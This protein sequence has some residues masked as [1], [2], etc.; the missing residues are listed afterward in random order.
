MN[1]VVGKNVNELFGIRGLELRNSEVYYNRKKGVSCNEKS[2]VNWPVGSL[3]LENILSVS[4]IALE[5]SLGR[6]D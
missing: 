5:L 4:K 1:E 3:I 6:K 2:Q